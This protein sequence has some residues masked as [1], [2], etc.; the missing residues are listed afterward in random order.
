M[1]TRSDV[2]SLLL[3]LRSAGLRIGVHETLTTEFLLGRLAQRPAPLAAALRALLVKSDQERESFDRVF[4]DWSSALQ[5]REQTA[6]K[7]SS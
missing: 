2:G 1:I 4:A 6:V 5:E 7:E 3:A